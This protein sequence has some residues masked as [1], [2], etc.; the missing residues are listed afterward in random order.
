ME[1][2]LLD[3]W[4][5]DAE[6]VPILD[7]ASVALAREE[8]RRVGAE[9]ALEPTSIAAMAI[10]ASELGHNHLCHA[11]R[12]A[13]VVRRIERNQ[14]RGIEVTA[15]DRGGGIIDP[16]A[17]LEGS[18]GPSEGSLG[19]GLAG[20]RRLSDEM[21]VDIRLGEGTCIRA[22]KFA[23]PLPRGEV[24]VFGRPCS[25]ETV[26]G[27]DAVFIRQ[28]GL[29]V[30]GLA[31]GLGHGPLAR[32]ASARA[33][34]EIRQHPELAPPLLFAGCDD[35]LAQT[36]GAVMTLVRI[37]P[38]ELEHTGV[39]NVGAHLYRRAGGSRRF[40]C[41]AGVIGVPDQRRA[42]PLR[43]RTPFSAGDVVVMFSDGLS[44]RLDLSAQLQLLR[45]HPIVIAHYLV[46]SGGRLD[47]DA[48]VLVAH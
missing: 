33:V 36:R 41:I 31:D 38:N 35:A 46:N 5:G 7:E 21:D 6:R 43:E 45:Q 16:T 30:V 25:G 9:L 44:S 11:R 20:V 19:N 15:A 23:S 12:G 26:S 47:D 37:D 8:V 39:G 3:A 29:L 10:V 28:D 27:D 14:V 4:L 2:D 48:T 24:A 18:Q 17:A 42:K 34:R 13:I 40:A 22:R 32:A 1:E